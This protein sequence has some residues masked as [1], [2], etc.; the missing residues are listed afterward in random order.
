MRGQQI[1]QVESN[2]RRLDATEYRV[3]SQSGRGDYQ[4]VSTEAGWYCSC[5]D[6]GFRG[7]KCKHAFAVELS[8]QIRRRIENARRVVPL[9][10]QSC[11]QCGSQHIKRDGLLHNKAGD[12]QRFECLQCGKRFTKNLGFERMRAKPEAITMAMQMYFGG[13][14]LRNVQKALKLQGANFSH[15]A[16][17]KWIRKYVG[18]MA[19]IR[20]HDGA[21]RLRH[22]EGGRDIREGEGRHE[23]SIRGDGR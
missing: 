10:F 2:V 4:V 14:S 22:M 16:I 8:L 18:L 19:G 11:L 21:E 3:K 15:V 23:V 1:A 20:L 7:V 6:A 17:Y 5:P 9:D 13:A 12:I